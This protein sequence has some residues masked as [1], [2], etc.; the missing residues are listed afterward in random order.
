M[1]HVRGSECRRATAHPRS[2]ALA[3]ARRRM[4]DGRS[5]PL[6]SLDMAA[7][8]NAHRSAG[9]NL[10]LKRKLYLARMDAKRW[11]AAWTAALLMAGC[12]GEEYRGPDPGLPKRTVLVWL[13]GDND[14]SA[15]C[16]AKIEAL[17]AGWRYTGSRCLIYYD[18]ADAPPRL[19][20]LRGGCAVTPAPYVETVAEYPEEDSAG[21][22]VLGRVLREVMADYPADSYGLVFASHASGWMPEGAFPPGAIASR[23]FGRDSHS[24]NAGRAT[25]MELEE[26]A[27]ALPDGGLDFILFEACHTA[28]VETAYALRRK[29]DYLLVS[30]A[31][32]LLPG[33]REIYPA[34]GRLLF[35]TSRPVEEALAAFGQAYFEWVRSQPADYASATLSLI[36]T[37]AM[38]ALAA[39]VRALAGKTAA[40]AWKDTDGLQHFDRPQYYGYG[41]P[42]FYDLGAWCERLGG[43]AAYRL[44]LVEKVVVWKAATPAFLLSYGGFEIRTYSGLTTYV[45]AADRPSL[46]DEWRRTAWAG[47]IGMGI[48]TEGS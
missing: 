32:L 11:T 41:T 14:L 44:G 6:G 43:A 21:A 3:D 2:A 24:G 28:G 31:E 8:S 12:V 23:S 34:H 46:D 4:D 37:Q 25:E 33:F 13:A 5:V 29:A 16:E 35:D 47:A 18:A 10:C 15:D 48:G 17:R 30:S 7:A 27:A 9:G 22:D 19:L 42:L 45:P 26:L 20:S 38:E 39:G 40:E 36:R 1:N